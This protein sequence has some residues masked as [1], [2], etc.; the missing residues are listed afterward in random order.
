M[1]DYPFLLDN[2][3]P[4]LLVGLYRLMRFYQ[5]S[6]YKMMPKKEQGWITFQSSQEERK[7]LDQYCQQSQRSKTEILRELVRSL[8]QQSQSLQ[9][10]SGK[11]RGKKDSGTSQQ[12]LASQKS[13]LKTLKVSARNVLKGTVKRVVTGSVNS[14]VALEIAPGVELISIITRSSAEELSLA[15]GREAYA[16]IKSS[17]ILI[18]TEQA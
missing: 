8:E 14:E 3:C 7:I 11:S 12:A 15:E 18:A 4:D 16:V 6:W 17:N 1:G 10:P 13:E 5:Q 2:S 9:L